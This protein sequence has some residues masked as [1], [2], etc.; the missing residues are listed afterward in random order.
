MVGG[1]ERVLVMGA[2]KRDAGELQARTENNR[3]VNFEVPEGMS[4]NRLIGTFVDVR[5]DQALPNSLRGTFLAALGSATDPNS[6]AASAAI[7][8]H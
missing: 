4:G 7:L 1:V 6:N 3:V 8:A 5:I 2:S